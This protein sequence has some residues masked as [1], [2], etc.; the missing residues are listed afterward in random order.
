MTP[1]PCFLN[2]APHRIGDRIA[3]KNHAPVEVSRRAP[4]S[5]N[6]RPMRPEK[7]FLIRIENR[8]QTDFGQIQPLPQEVDPD[9]HIKHAA[10]EIAYNLRPLQR[11][12]VRVQIPHLHAEIV[13]I[14]R[15]VFGHALGQG[16]DQNAI[17]LRRFQLALQPASYPPAP[18]PAAPR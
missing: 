1:A 4:S 5:L 10:P 7:A 12:N 18:S 13:I 2:G 14:L 8:H 15:E 3:V 6:Q 16:R 9:Q 11:L 17:S